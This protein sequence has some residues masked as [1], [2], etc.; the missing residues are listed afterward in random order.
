MEAVR[1]AVFGLSARESAIMLL[2]ALLLTV[3]VWYLTT[4]L[5]S[6]LR[7]YP[8]PFLAGRLSRISLLPQLDQLVSI[9]KKKQIVR[10]RAD[11]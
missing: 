5:M 1:E 4:Y 11:I 8:G 2:Q 3:P 10:S 6:P 9:K 7:Q